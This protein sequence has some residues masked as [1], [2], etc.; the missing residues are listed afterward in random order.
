MRHWQILANDHPAG[1][2]D[3]DDCIELRQIGIEYAEL[4]YLSYVDRAGLII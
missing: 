1:G 4:I 3:S 2:G